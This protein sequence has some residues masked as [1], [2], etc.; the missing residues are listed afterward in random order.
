MRLAVIFSLL[1]LSVPAGA[2][3]WGILD[4]HDA[5]AGKT[6]T[7]VGLADVYLPMRQLPPLRAG[8]GG[9]LERPPSRE[10]EEVIRFSGSRTVCFPRAAMRLSSLSLARA[11]LLVDRDGKVYLA[12]FGSSPGDD[13]VSVRQVQSITC[14]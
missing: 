6:I 4:D 10:P 11:L 9:Q 2:Q 5:L 1:S 8:T 12:V 14:P 13:S 7:D 3:R